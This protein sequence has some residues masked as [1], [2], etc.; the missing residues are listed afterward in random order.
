MLSDENQRVYQY[1]DNAWNIKGRFDSV[2]DHDEDAVW[3][4]EEGNHE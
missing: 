4:H 2:L 1:E 3:S